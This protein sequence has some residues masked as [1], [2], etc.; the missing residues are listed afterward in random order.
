VLIRATAT[1]EGLIWW[2]NGGFL[3]LYLASAVFTYSALSRPA[4]TF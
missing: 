4:K 1:T 3:A 2:L